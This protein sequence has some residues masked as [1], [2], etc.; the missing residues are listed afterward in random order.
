MTKQIIVEVLAKGSVHPCV[1]LIFLHEYLPWHLIDAND[2]HPYT[3]Q[4]IT[5]FD[6]LAGSHHDVLNDLLNWCY[7]S[8]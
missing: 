3:F 6:L 4:K 8:V 7:L 5:A 1:L 2:R